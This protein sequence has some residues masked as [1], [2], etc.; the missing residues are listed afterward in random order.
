MGVR[1]SLP[2]QLTLSIEVS[3]T[4]EFV[5]VIM[6]SCDG[7]YQFMICVGCDNKNLPRAKGCK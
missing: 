1:Q 6:C 5:L 4:I 2:R 7:K 3:R